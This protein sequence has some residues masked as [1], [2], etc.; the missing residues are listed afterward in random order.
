MQGLK[1]G[2]IPVAIIGIV[3]CKVSTENGAITPGDLLTTSSTPG[4]AMK[5]TNRQA[6][7]G[8]ILGKALQSLAS[9]TGM[10]HVMILMQ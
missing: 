2:E 3:S 6:A 4:Y 9:G 7:A 8:A 1:A 10:I 5:V